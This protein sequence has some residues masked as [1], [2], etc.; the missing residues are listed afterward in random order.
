LIGSPSQT[1]RRNPIIP[2]PDFTCGGGGGGGGDIIE[3][4]VDLDES[5]APVDYEVGGV[6]TPKS[7]FVL[8]H[9]NVGTVIV[10]FA[11]T[12]YYVTWSGALQ[13][14][15]NGANITIPLGED[16][17]TGEAGSLGSYWRDASGWH[18]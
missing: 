1:W 13:L 11:V 14:N 10:D 4:H 7:V 6:I 9:G 3:A 2:G 12:K 5:G 15:A 18:L 16:S 17:A 8:S